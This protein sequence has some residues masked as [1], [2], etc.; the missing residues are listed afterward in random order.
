MKM[1]FNKTETQNKSKFREI[2]TFKGPEDLSFGVM[3]YDTT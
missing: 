1:E 3:D 2:S